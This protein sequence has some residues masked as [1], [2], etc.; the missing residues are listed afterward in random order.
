MNFEIYEKQMRSD[1]ADLAKT[2]GAVLA[3]AIG[4]HPNLKLQQIKHRGK[5]PESLKKKLEEAGAL[6]SE[7]IEDLVKDLAGCR[8]VFYTNSD[9]SRFLSSG[10]VRDNFE[11]D[12]DRTKI[13]HPSP[14]TSSATE[15]F[16][17]TNYVVRFNDQRIALPE[18]TRFR[19]MWCEVQV[20]TTLNHAWSEMA[21]D[22]IYKKPKLKEFGGRLMQGIEQ[23]MKK[24]MRDYLLPAGYE[25]Q[26]VATDFERLSIGKELFDQDALTA[27]ANCKDNNELHNLLERFATY[28][29][30]YYDDLQ[31]VHH[32]I[33]SA[34]VS[35]IKQARETPM[36]P[37]DNTPFDALPGYTVEQIMR[38]ADAIV[39]RLRYVNE[40][41]VEA[42][43]DAICELFP[44]AKSDEERQL[45][46]QSAKNLSEHEL[47]VWKQVGPLVQHLLVERI[48]RIDIGTLASIKPVVMEVL[49]QVLQPEVEGT[50]STYNTLTI[51][52]GAVVPSE[53]LIDIRANA[54]KILKSLFRDAKTDAERHEVV[55]QLSIATRTPYSGNYSNELLKTIL[56]D[57]ANIV[58]FYKE[59][60]VDQSYE[61]LQK[62]EHDLLW[63]YRR[64]R[65]MPNDT[66]NDPTIAIS[67]Q[68]LTEQ[69]LA[70][71][72]LLNSNQGF[73]VYKT[74]V[75]LQSVFPPAWEDASF[76]LEGQEAYRS[77]QLN[78]LLDEVT[79]ENADKWLS[80]LS[81]CAQ[82]DS[83][84]LATL[85]RFLEDLGRLKPHILITY[86]D[87]LDERLAGF[88]P[89]ML[90][91]LEGG[92]KGDVAQEKVRNW[93]D[94]RQYLPQ[95]IWYQRFAANFDADVLERALIAAI[96]V[97]D[98]IAV[99]NAVSTSVVRHGEV[100]GGLI[101]RV[102]LPAIGYLTAKGDT[103]WVNALWP[104]QKKRALLQDL[105]SEQADQ[106]LAS[107]VRHH[108]IDYHVGD[109]LA[110]IAASWPTK[111]VDFFG[112]RL[113]IESKPAAGDKKRYEAIP[114]RFYLLHEQLAK[115]PEYLVEKARSWFEKDKLLFQYRGG[116]LLSNVFPNFPAELVRILQSLIQGHD[117]ANI[118]FVVKILRNYEGK[119]FIYDLCKEIVALL[120]P[121]DTLLNEIEA[122]LDSTGVVTGEFGFV[123]AYK[124]KRTEFESWLSD[125][126]ESVQ[127]FARRHVLSLDR[128]IAAEQRRS[129]EDLE[130][131]KRE[132]GDD[133][134]DKRND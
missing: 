18:Y 13:H 9:V 28:V 106:V 15:L 76:D 10:I 46:L 80:V 26:K 68:R 53:M 104:S 66:A 122:A 97:G 37:I 24:I 56:D 111:L 38:L 119:A 64:N 103:R 108:Q 34:V 25:F 73:V 58:E 36:R 61:L 127:S 120:P 77:Q 6:E 52:K 19:G 71:R 90:T 2:I 45:L 105:N 121:E 69:I 30:P 51:H 50:S 49:G 123:E 14:D 55:Q 134:P 81:R 31:S 42:T 94:T 22:T 107:L 44:G 89:A 133:A 35:A 129:E 85:G 70:F 117:R 7:N 16:I 91:G 75:G 110:A 8:L 82:T 79:E 131:R 74:L 124:R 99:L 78:E 116:R 83:N 132:Y 40:E 60:A 17:S 72:D 63:L 113:E 126:Q 48:R 65:D 12:W 118:E 4:A 98:D 5:D 95:I 23:R 102:F 62:L 11:I 32:E 86:L 27:L 96:E 109:A 33:R 114:F 20:Q 41:A 43:F 87:R 101:E 84:D 47:D 100:A 59:V 21:H 125:P 3:A 39:D 29:F 128:R 1:C 92:A 93:V 54:I 67:R 88:L 115:T 57:T 130:M 112:S